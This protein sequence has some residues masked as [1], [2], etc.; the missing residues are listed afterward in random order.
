MFT[1][2][3]ETRL[4][5]I[6]MNQK[7]LCQEDACLMGVDDI[8][9]T[10]NIY[11]PASFM[12]PRHWASEQVSDALAIAAALGNPTFFITMTCNPE[13]P[14]IQS[15]LRPSQNH[16]DIPVVVARV[17]HRKLSMLCQTL[18][19]LFPNQHQVYCISSVEFQKRGLPH[20]HILVKYSGDCSNPD[21][22]DQIVSA[23]V[24]SDPDDHNLVLKYMI[25]KHPSP[26]RPPSAYCQRIDTAGNRVCR[27]RYP[28]PLCDFTTIEPDGR[29]NY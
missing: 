29:V 26:D 24:P 3:L 9:N 11:L 10:D 8:N 25:H 2:N 6:R 7:R 4:N 5:Y 19:T 23:E 22:I 28:K 27:F 14:E 16:T 21:D 17:F 12:G 15:Q 20:A 18:K 13:W 1:R